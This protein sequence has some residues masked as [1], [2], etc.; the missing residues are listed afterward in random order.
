MTYEDLPCACAKQELYRFLND[1]PEKEL[2][3]YVNEVIALN[4]NLSVDVAKYKKMLRQNEVKQIMLH[5]G[6]IEE[7]NFDKKNPQPVKAG[8]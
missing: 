8:D 4:R 1:I 3:D 2:R 6:F 7:E 5:F